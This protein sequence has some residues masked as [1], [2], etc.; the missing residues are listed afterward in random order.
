MLRSTSSLRDMND[1]R[2][3]AICALAQLHGGQLKPACTA[4]ADGADHRQAPELVVIQ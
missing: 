2:G 4:V 3:A 1:A